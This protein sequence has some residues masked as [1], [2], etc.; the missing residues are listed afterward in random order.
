MIQFSIVAFFEKKKE[1]YGP[2]KKN[3]KR[4]IDHSIPILSGAL[5]LMW[6]IC[7]NSRDCHGEWT[8]GPQ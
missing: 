2:A 6:P 1:K 4:F 5:P 8:K 7:Y 3:A